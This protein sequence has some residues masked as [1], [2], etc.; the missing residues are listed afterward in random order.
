[1]SSSD[2]LISIIVPV[3]NEEANIEWFFHEM[4]AYLNKNCKDYI[5]EYVLIDDGSTDNSLAEI[6]KIASRH[7]TAQFISFSRNFGKEAATTAGLANARGA[8]AIMIDSDGQHPYQ[9]IKDFISHWEAGSKVV[10]GVRSSN[11]KEGMV[12]HYGSKLFYWVLRQLDTS[13]I[14]PSA[15]DFRL[16]DRQV[17]DEFNNLTEHNRITRG[18]IDWLGFKRSYVEFDAVARKY[19]QATYSHAKLLRLALNSF[20]AHSTRPL[21]IIG[22]LGVIVMLVS[23]LLAIF[24]IFENW[25]FNDPMSLNITGTALLAVFLSFLTGVTLSCQGLLA[26]YVETIHSETQNRPLYIVAESSSKTS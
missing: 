20:V 8:A 19:G 2:N 9:L 12:K 5:F 26:L 13:D 11:E 14:T 23:G 7:E 3:H 22:G 25:V 6:K 16:V 18:L 4:R 15:T 10:V 21:K 17:L 1:M 24:L